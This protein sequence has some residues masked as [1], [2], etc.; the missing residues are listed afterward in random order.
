VPTVSRYGG[1]LIV[2]RSKE[3]HVLQWSTHIVSSRQQ[4]VTS[5]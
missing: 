3:I 5:P 2:T 1:Q 4:T